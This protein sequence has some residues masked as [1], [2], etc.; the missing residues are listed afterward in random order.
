[1]TKEYYWNLLNQ[2]SSVEK[3]EADHQSEMHSE[4]NNLMAMAFAG[5]NRSGENFQIESQLPEIERINAENKKSLFGATTEVP[6][7]IETLRI[8]NMDNT[9]YSIK[10]DLLQ[11]CMKSDY[12]RLVLKEKVEANVSSQAEIISMP[13]ITPVVEEQE[14]V[15]IAPVV[16]EVVKE[17]AVPEGRSEFYVP[18]FIGDLKYNR[19]KKFTKPLSTFCFNHTKMSL[20]LENG[21]KA[22]VDFNVY[23]LTFAE[24]APITDIMVTAVTGHVIRA[25]I[26]RGVSASVEIKFDEMSFIVRGMWEDGK[27]VTQIN[28]LDAHFAGKFKERTTSYM[29]E[30]RTYTTYIQE[31][32]YGKTY[33]FFPAAVGLNAD[34]GFAKCAAVITDGNDISVIVSNEENVFSIIDPDGAPEQILLYWSGGKD[35]SLH[36]EIEEQD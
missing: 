36:I 21:R 26:S 29:P 5:L 23:P 27:F 11:K 9:V 13:D 4:A 24:D 14:E 16:E 3:E 34:N 18:Q 6:E 10:T 12:N 1:M 2:V 22:V 7:L 19:D 15:K 35:P 17:E 28:C 30:M 31:E 8:K 32:I 20:P 33:N 25:G